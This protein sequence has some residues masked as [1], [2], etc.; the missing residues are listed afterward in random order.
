MFPGDASFAFH[1]QPH[2]SFRSR[3][4]TKVAA[5]TG[6]STMAPPPQQRPQKRH[7]YSGRWDVANNIVH[8]PYDAWVALRKAN[9]FADA[10]IKRGEPQWGSLK[11]I[12]DPNK[13]CRW[14]NEH[15]IVTYPAEMKP[16]MKVMAANPFPKKTS[17]IRTRLLI[18]QVRTVNECT[19]RGRL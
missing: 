12:F 9:P 1:N 10:Y 13:E 4:P 11:H 6:S 17:Q 14:G 15:E 18:W 5:F 8:A 7:F 16:T 2:I 3:F 19:L